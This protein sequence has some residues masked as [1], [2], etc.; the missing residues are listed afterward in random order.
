MRHRRRCALVAT[1]SSVVCAAEAINATDRRGKCIDKIFV[2]SNGIG[3]AGAKSRAASGSAGHPG[4][5]AAVHRGPIA[6][7]G[8]VSRGP[9]AIGGARA[10]VGDVVR[11][12]EED[13]EL[14]KLLRVSG[15]GR[16]A[17]ERSAV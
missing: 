2:L 9:I 3:V 6:I 16:I 4:L 15:C 17:K 7:A 13:E 12:E 8:D 1:K 11:R 14:L 5:L 10:S